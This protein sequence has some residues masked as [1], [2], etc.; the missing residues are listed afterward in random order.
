MYLQMTKD[1][2]TTRKAGL[3]AL[4]RMAATLKGHMTPASTET[5]DELLEKARDKWVELERGTEA[6]NEG[7]HV[8][9][10]LLLS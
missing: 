5:L 8:H 1:E 2:L 3:H 6:R 4:E 10:E 9:V 7:E